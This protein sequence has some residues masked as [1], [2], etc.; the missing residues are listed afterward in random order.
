MD[1]DT[2]IKPNIETN[3]AKNNK[4]TPSFTKLH[5]E[6]HSIQLKVQTKTIVI[7]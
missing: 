7:Y 4:T 2:Y 3:L 5:T 1:S 6:V